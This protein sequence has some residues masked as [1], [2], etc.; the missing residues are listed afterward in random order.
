MLGSVAVVGVVVLFGAPVSEP[1]TYLRFF[2]NETPPAEYVQ[3]AE[4]NITVEKDV[5]EPEKPSNKSV[6]AKN[7]VIEAP[8]T[9]VSVTVAGI[10]AETNARRAALGLPPFSFN[11]QLTVAAQAKAADM[12]ARQYFEH[13]S[14]DGKGPGDLADA[15]GYDYLS[16]AENLALGDYEKSGEV[17]DGWMDSPGHRENIVSTTY[18]DI[19]VAVRQGMFEGDF[20]WF[21]VQEF[22][23]PASDCSS[24]SVVLEARIEDSRRLLEETQ[25]ILEE[26][27]KE[28]EDA[29]PK[30]GSAYN[31]K[32]DAYNGLVKS[33][34]ELVAETEKLIKTY[35]DEVKVYNE[36]AQ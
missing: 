2:E 5:A 32:V 7:V 10:L 13:E 21:A 28:I 14:P 12:V 34:N 1:T 24:P 3:I 36:C 9:D 4:E 33:Y 17:V 25:S 31:A 35:N 18:S 15:A 16:I 27:L 20:V 6:P 30:R 29:E 23:R 11:A 26:A 8:I 22:G 19:G